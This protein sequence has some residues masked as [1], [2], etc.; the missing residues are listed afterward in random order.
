MSNI[1]GS[2]VTSTGFAIM[3]LAVSAGVGY[4]ELGMLLGFVGILVGASFVAVGVRMGDDPTKPMVPAVLPRVGALI[5]AFLH[6][7]LA[8]VGL[9][10]AS[11]AVTAVAGGEAGPVLCFAMLPLFLLGL[12]FVHIQI[13]EKY[14]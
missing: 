11:S 8:V 1:P 9:L 7:N 6:R 3:L 4:G 12:C 2:R 13:L 5:A 10:M 14:W